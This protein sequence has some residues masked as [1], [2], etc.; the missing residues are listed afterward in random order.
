[1]PIKLSP[2]QMADANQMMNKI[3][4]GDVNPVTKGC[5]LASSDKVRV[6]HRRRTAYAQEPGNGN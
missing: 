6:L 5:W 3:A 4:I 2:S 1:M